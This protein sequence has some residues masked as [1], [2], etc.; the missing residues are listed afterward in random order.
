MTISQ[1]Q[2]APRQ[3]E[4]S[5]VGSGNVGRPTP[6]ESVARLP[7]TGTPYL[8]S[9]YCLISTSFTAICRREGRGTVHLNTCAIAGVMM[10]AKWNNIPLGARTALLLHMGANRC[11][12]KTSGRNAVSRPCPTL[13]VVSLPMCFPGTALARVIGRSVDIMDFHFCFLSVCC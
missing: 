6:P 11:P 4:L 12:F 3:F 13:L 7:E 8:P 5:P 1:H 9:S 2:N 10:I